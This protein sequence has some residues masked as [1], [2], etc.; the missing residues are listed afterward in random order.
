LPRTPVFWLLLVL[1]VLTIGTGL[2]ILWEHRQQIAEESRPAA[3]GPIRSLAPEFRLAGLDGRTVRLSDYRGKVVLLNFWATWCPP[4]KAEMPDLEWLHRTYGVEHD[5]EVVGINL[6]ESAADVE[7]FARQQGISFPLLLDS[8]G[9]VTNR[10]FAVRNL[11]TS[12]IIDRD[13]FIRDAWT[14]QILR[15]AIVARL[16]RV[17]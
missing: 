11:P 7:D 16:K 6:E 9:D 10:W 14:G 1:S 12:M 13:G 3:A 4:C 5:F 2:L 17:W 15:E 8:D